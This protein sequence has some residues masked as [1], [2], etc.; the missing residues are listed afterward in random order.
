MLFF[1]QLCECLFV[2]VF[3]LLEAL[4]IIGF[5][6]V[7]HLLEAILHLLEL[8]NML[9]ISLLY[10]IGQIM[11]LIVKLLDLILQLSN[12]LILSSDNLF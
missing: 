8:L 1:L 7:K 10:V 2:L 11:N 4:I 9:D 3:R 6:R 12:F 5:G